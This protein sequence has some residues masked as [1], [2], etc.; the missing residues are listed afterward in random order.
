MEFH[1]SREGFKNVFYRQLA[2]K[3]SVN[4]IRVHLDK[5]VLQRDEVFGANVKVLVQVV[6]FF[7][8]KAGEHILHH[9]Q[10]FG[11]CHRRLGSVLPAKVLE[12]I[13]WTISSILP[14]LG[15]FFDH[16]KLLLSVESA[17]LF[18][19]FCVSDLTISVL[20]KVV[21]QS[22]RLV[23]TQSDATLLHGNMKFYLCQLIIAIGVHNSEQISKSHSLTF[24]E[25]LKFSLR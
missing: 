12:K 7:F 15:S 10:K 23:T 24:D 4:D 11:F 18:N 22:K 2:V 3:S 13:L 1:P 6:L 8:A 19:Q 25:V 17:E 9:L 16:F 5:P 14:F 20:I 21:E